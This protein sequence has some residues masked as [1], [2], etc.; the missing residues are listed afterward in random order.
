MFFDYT[1]SDVLT[2]EKIVRLTDMTELHQ[3]YRTYL[4]SLDVGEIKLSSK[5]HT[6]RNVQVEFEV[7]FI[8]PANLTHFK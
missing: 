2:N 4:T 8:V 7:V 6:R 1:R 3:S 5:K